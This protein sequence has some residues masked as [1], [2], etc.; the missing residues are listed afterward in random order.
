MGPDMKKGEAAAFV[1][2]VWPDRQDTQRGPTRNPHNIMCLFT[3]TIRMIK[4]RLSCEARDL[5]ERGSDKF[6]DDI[7]NSSH[8]SFCNSF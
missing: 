1:M 4:V 6:D 7:S 3:T 8:A 2:A 5:I